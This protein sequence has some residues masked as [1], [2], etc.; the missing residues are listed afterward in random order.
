MYGSRKSAGKKGCS[1]GCGG[2]GPC[3]KPIP[4]QVRGG[5]GYAPADSGHLGAPARIIRR[6]VAYMPYDA[7]R[8]A[9][10]ATAVIRRDEP[11]DPRG[12]YKGVSA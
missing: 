2:H 12:D 7:V 5:D 9:P 3:G 11:Y 4:V 6:G 10:G 8:I 1:C